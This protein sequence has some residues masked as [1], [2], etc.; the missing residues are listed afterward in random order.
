[1]KI[2]TTL[3]YWCIIALNA[4]GLYTRSQVTEMQ[5]GYVASINRLTARCN[6]CIFA[7]NAAEYKKQIET[8]ESEEQQMSSRIEELRE[9]IERY[10][11]TP[12]E[13]AEYYKDVLKGL[14]KAVKEVPEY[15]FLNS[16]P[17]PGSLSVQSHNSTDPDTKETYTTIRGR[18]IA[19]DYLTAHINLES[20]MYERLKMCFNYMAQ[21]GMLQGVVER[22]VNNGAMQ[23]TI[24][25]NEQNTNYEVHF[26]MVAKNYNPDTDFVIM[27]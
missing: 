7:K 17:L 4:I 16:K 25:Y 12:D 2:L 24:S 20:N 10:R 1:M 27:K 13:N 26:E 18:F 11:N 6:T 5:D 8:M 14:N 19:D 9:T 23:F 15:Q 22:L 21:Y 3:R